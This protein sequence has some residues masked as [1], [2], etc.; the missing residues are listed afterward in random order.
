MWFRPSPTFRATGHKYILGTGNQESHLD[1]LASSSSKLVGRTS[2]LHKATLEVGVQEGNSSRSG[3]PSLGDTPKCAGGVCI[4]GSPLRP[5]LP[6]TVLQLL[7]LRVRE[8]HQGVGCSIRTPGCG[9]I[10]IQILIAGERVGC[11]PQVLGQG[12]LLRIQILVVG[13]GPGCNPW[14]PDWGIILLI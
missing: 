12:V 13:M 3:I 8:V 6:L 4:T 11:D 5:G 9:I 14:T 2:R 1:Q 10:G 7:N